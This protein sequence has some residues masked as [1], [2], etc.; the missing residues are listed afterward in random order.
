M[1]P[2]FSYLGHK[3]GDFPVAE[4][5]SKEILASAH[6]SRTYDD[7]VEYVCEALQ[8]FYKGLSNHE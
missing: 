3:E 6:V 8:D 1:Q 5:V 7:E 4:R 2:C